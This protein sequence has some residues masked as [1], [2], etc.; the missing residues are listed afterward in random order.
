MASNGENRITV[1]VTYAEPLKQ[2]IISLDV[3]PGITAIEA[4]ALSGIQEKFASIGDLDSLELG[5][6]SKK[7]PPDQILHQGDRVE[8]YRPLLVDPK[9]ARRLKAEVAAR[10][11]KEARQTS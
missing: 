5:I 6:F 8:I 2:D 4:V 9:E 3:E 1:E 10:R 7:C 11:E